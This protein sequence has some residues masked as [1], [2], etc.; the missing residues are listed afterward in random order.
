MKKV[1]TLMGVALFLSLN[2]SAVSA[3]MCMGLPTPKESLAELG[4][5]FQ[6]KVVVAKRGEWT[7]AVE[8]VLMRDR[9]VGTSC[10]SRYNLGESYIFFADVEQTKKRA[11]Y[12]PRAC[13]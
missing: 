7:I 13:T 10:A 9:S 11:I 4:A 6:G 1:I 8:K 3:C 5:V 2:T 12:H